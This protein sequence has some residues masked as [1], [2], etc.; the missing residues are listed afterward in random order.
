MQRHSI[1]TARFK[2]AESFDQAVK[3]LPEFGFPVVIKADGLAAGKGVVIAH[4]REEA[5]NTLDEFMRQRTLGSAGERVIWKKCWWVK[6][7]PLLF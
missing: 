3:A 4:T 5:E 7:S 6:N 1:P 2:V